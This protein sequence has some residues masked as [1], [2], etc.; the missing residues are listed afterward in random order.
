[1]R[2][3]NFT[4]LL[5][6]SLIINS[7]KAQNEIS[8]Y[9]ETYYTRELNQPPSGN[10]PSFAYAHGRANEVN[11]NLAFLKMAR[12]DSNFRAN[13]ALATGTYQNANYAAENGVLRNILEANVGIL[14]SK[15]HEIWLDA[16][17]MPSHIGFES[18]LGK[19]CDNFSR[20]IMADN[21]PYFETGVKIS[22]NLNKN[23]SLAGL[24][25][26]GWQRISLA[27]GSS[28][29]SFGTQITFKNEK[30]T[31]NSSS[32]LGSD[33]PDSARLKRF[34]HNF[35][36]IFKPNSTVSTTFAYDIGFQQQQIGKNDFDRWQSV[37]GSIRFSPARARGHHF[38]L[39]GE[40][41][42]DKKLVIV[43][44]ANPDFRVSGLT[45]GWD[46]DVSANAL[47]RFEV[48]NLS[49]P[50]PIFESKNGLKTNNTA[51]STA[52]AISF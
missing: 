25:L 12:T 23:W 27:A 9:V 47:L 14:L 42:E 45:I 52:I 50:T 19:D 46:Y 38:V 30:L 21:S 48:K 8:G 49:N 29:P 31:V 51:I 4:F 18:A 7:L 10:R 5:F 2:K 34:F 13:L 32:F 1:M 39:R 11:I 36:L 22:K 17:V 24:V 40:Y 20:S 16:G 6:F 26:N 33:R 43:N 3:L 15:K 28:K 37:V 44:S 35:Y 41:F